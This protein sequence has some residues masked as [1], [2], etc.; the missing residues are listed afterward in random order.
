MNIN[1][2]IQRYFYLNKVLDVQ[3]DFKKIEQHLN[4]ND[5]IKKILKNDVENN[6]KVIKVL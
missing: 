1:R 6:E 4:E 2:F 3:I 5:I